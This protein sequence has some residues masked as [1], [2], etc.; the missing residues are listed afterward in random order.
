MWEDAFRLIFTPEWESNKD[1]TEPSEM[2]ACFPTNSFTFLC[3]VD[4]PG[5]QRVPA[6]QQR[7]SSVGGDEV[8]DL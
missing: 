8:R 7:G 2:R 3:Y 4:V 1:P 5:K 6:A